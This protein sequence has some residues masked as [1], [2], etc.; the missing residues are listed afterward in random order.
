[1]SQKQDILEYLKDGNEI[2]P[3]EALKKFGCFRLGARIWDLK[4]EGWEIEA[5]TT[6]ENGKRFSRYKLK[7]NPQL[8]LFEGIYNAMR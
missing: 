2:T 7:T 5:E 8:S 6:E 4:T 1:M 3:M